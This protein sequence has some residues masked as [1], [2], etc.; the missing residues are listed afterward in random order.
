M[1]VWHRVYVR[2]GRGKGEVPS[3][4]PPL[5]GGRRLRETVS[6]VSEG[7]WERGRGPEGHS[8]FRPSLRRPLL[9]RARL[10]AFA[11]VFIMVLHGF[12]VSLPAMDFERIFSAADFTL[13][14]SGGGLPVALEPGGS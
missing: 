6:E 10:A 8:L 11:A 4:P 7:G 13:A 9:R 12:V 2:F 5:P 14:F 3:S 1:C